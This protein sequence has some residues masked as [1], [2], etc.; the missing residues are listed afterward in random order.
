MTTAAP[1]STANAIAPPA[2]TRAEDALRQVEE[3]ERQMVLAAFEELKRRDAG[4]LRVAIRLNRETS[5]R[6]IVYLGI[7]E[8]RSLDRLRKLYS[9]LRQPNGGKALRF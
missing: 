3:A 9:Q 4:E 1:S 8:Q 6:E 7:H 2:P 5:V